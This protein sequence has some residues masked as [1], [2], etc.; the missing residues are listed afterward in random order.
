MSERTTRDL[1]TLRVNTGIQTLRLRESFERFDELGVDWR[2]LLR[3]YAEWRDVVSQS[4]DRPAAIK[5]KAVR[6]VGG[7]E[8]IIAVDTLAGPG[9]HGCL[10]ETLAEVAV[11]QTLPV[12]VSVPM[13]SDA[14]AEGEIDRR[15]LCVG[16]FV[17]AAGGEPVD[18]TVIV[19]IGNSRS[20]V[21]VLEGREGVPADLERDLSLVPLGATVPS[22]NTLLPRRRIMRTRAQEARK[23]EERSV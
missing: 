23:N 18:V 12:V 10:V 7:L 6:A 2:Q 21:G 8:L 11:A 13:V 3:D 5:M 22:A 17:L 19:D 16:T 4:A 1:G 9:E 14:A 20:T 15:P